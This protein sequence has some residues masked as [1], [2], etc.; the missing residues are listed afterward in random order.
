MRKK[1]IIS[2]NDIRRIVRTVLKEEAEQNPDL[3]TATNNMKM[4]MRGLLD[5][6]ESM[7]RSLNP[8]VRS[9]A[10]NMIYDL[11]LLSRQIVHF[12]KI[13][14]LPESRTRRLSESEDDEFIPHG[15]FAD[16]NWG[17]KEVQISDSGDAARFRRNYGEPEDPTDWL[18]IQYHPD[19][20]DF[21]GYCS[22]PW[23]DECLSNYMRIQ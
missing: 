3:K 16:S 21:G 22:T 19:R 13:V 6:L 20:E 5:A 12:E 11:A 4:H 14:G 9:F 1:T 18:E 8:K 7:E 10:S 23:G 17:G 2:E 15:H